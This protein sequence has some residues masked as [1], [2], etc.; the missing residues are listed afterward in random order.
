MRIYKTTNGGGPLLEEVTQ[1]PLSVA[2]IEDDVNFSLAPNPT[3]GRFTVSSEKEQIKR[4][5]VFD[6]QGKAVLTTFPRAFSAEVDLT[7]FPEGVYLVQ[8]LAGNQILT[9]KVMVYSE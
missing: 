6:L 2:E 7:A 8:V 3:S 9:G 4:V 5:E 1:V